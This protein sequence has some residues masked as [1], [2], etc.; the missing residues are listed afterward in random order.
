M[1]SKVVFVQYLM[2]L[3]VSE[4]VDPT[5]KLGVRI[6]WPNDIYAEAE[7]VADA[8]AGTKGKAK[9][10]GILVNTNLVNGEWRLVVGCGINILN[11]LPT[12][13]LSQLHALHMARSPQSTIK[14]P[15]MEETFAR[16]MDTFGDMWTTFT[17]EG[18]AP[19][20]NEYYG[21]WLHREQEVTLTTTTPHQKV[22]IHG[23]TRDHGLLRCKVVKESKGLTP[24]YTR[25]DFGETDE[26]VD[27]QPDGN[28]F[29]LMSGLIK[30]KV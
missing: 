10:G 13:S 9:L 21:R 6:K 5:G 7:G 19:F 26:F 8:P 23:I 18:F 29:D 4:A 3:A 15:T 20:F 30:R 25:G 2:A 17:E 28:S 24:L 27:L 11:A 14:P 16:I 1:S 12:F 22:V